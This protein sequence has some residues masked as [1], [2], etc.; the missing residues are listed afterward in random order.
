MAKRATPNQ[1]SA[2]KHA[3]QLFKLFNSNNIS[4]DLISL[5]FQQNYNGRNE[6]INFFKVSNYKVGRNLLVNRFHSLNNK[7]DY[8]WLNDSSNIFK[9]KCKHLLL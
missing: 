9:V 6:K 1:M 4:E 7:I 8:N 3:L 2:Y 5:N